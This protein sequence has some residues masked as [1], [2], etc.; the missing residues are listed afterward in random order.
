[1]SKTIALNGKFLIAMPSLSESEFEGSVI[2]LLEHNETGSFGLIVN[3]PLDMT[4]GEVI[5]SLNADFDTS[6]Y[7]KPAFNGGPVEPQRGF[8]IHPA[9]TDKHWQGQAQ[10][11]HGITVTTSSDILTAMANGENIRH[12]LIALGYSGW[13]QQQLEDEIQA[14]NWLVCDIAPQ[15]VF[16]T[17]WHQRLEL[18]LKHIG[19]R[20]EQLSLSVGHA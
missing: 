9:A 17:A 15:K 10:F 1:M 3:H 5:A 19:V 2:Y 8:I 14:N 16:S 13:E 20:Y 6:L 18:C 11:E 12:Y 4:E 7:N